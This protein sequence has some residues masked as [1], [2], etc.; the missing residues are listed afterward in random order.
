MEILTPSAPHFGGIFEAGVKSM[1][2]HLRRVVGETKLLFEEL[3]TVINQ[4]ESVLNSRPISPMSSDGSDLEPL[5]PGHFLV[6]R[7]L[8]NIV[9]PQLIDVYDNRLSR[10][11]LTTKFVQQIWK[12]WHSDYLN[13]LQQRHKWQ[14]NKINVKPNTMVLIKEDN[15]PPLKWLLGRI[16][17]VV[18][19]KD[20]KVR[21]VVVKTKNGLFKRPITKIC[22]L[23]FA[24]N[25]S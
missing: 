4:I 2:T 14:F 25:K 6:G 7:P 22:I 19:G 12:R 3:L 23:P 15:L 21:V 18:T 1:K 24:E 13:Q 17:E 8:T 11:Q 5:T 20:G 9:E 10:W 16:E